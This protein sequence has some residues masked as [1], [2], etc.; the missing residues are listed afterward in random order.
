MRQSNAT[1][2]NIGNDNDK[3]NDKCLVVVMLISAVQG[4]I[5]DSKCW[6]MISIHK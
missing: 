2:D 3:E 4:M 5:K 6:F 1:E